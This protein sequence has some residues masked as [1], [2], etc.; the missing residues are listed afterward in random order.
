MILEE[1]KIRN[2]PLVWCN[3]KSWPFPPIFLL[4]FSLQHLQIAASA[5]IRA[6]SGRDRVER[7]Y[8]I[9]LRTCNLSQVLVSFLATPQ[10]MWVL[11]PSPGIERVPPAVEARSLNH[12]TA[13]RPLSSTLNS[14]FI[15][16]IWDFHC[17]LIVL[18]SLQ[19][20]L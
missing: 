11:S 18:C 2:S 17:T 19:I 1:K 12:W 10:G 9:F 15:A 6:F 5:F 13:G 3:F 20:D 16:Q 14:Q 7:A 8:S 4:K